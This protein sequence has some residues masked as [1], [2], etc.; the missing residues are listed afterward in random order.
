MTQESLIKIHRKGLI[1]SSVLVIYL[2]FLLNPTATFF[3]E[4]YHLL[5]LDFLYVGYQIF[6]FAGYFYYKLSNYT[7][8]SILAGLVVFGL[9]AGIKAF[10]R[11]KSKSKEVA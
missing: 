8:I 4:A 5:K 9:Y 3:Y 10:R 11:R 7:M 1:F 6:K 2:Q